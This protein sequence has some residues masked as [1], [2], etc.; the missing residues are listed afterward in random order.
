ML[1]AGR[2]VIRK[3]ILA[4]FHWDDLAHGLALAL[5]IVYVA[6]YTVMFPILL[7]IEK[8]KLKEGPQPSASDLN[9]FVRFDVAIQL[10]AWLTIYL[11][12]LSLLLYFRTIFGISPV[13]LKVWWAVLGFTIIA[14]GVNFISPLWTCATPSQLFQLGNI[15]RP[16][17]K[18][19]QL[20]LHKMHALHQRHTK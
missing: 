15:P 7:A 6:C 8:G 18:P 14:F 2:Y 1:T 4:K 13:F 12:K 20:T 17:A 19:T 11:V 5:S 10:L 9:R 3:T 16:S